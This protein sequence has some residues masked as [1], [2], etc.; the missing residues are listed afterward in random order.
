MGTTG[1]DE[2]KP[3]LKYLE[4][5]CGSLAVLVPF[6]DA[7]AEVSMSSYPI[8]FHANHFQAH[9]AVGAAIAAISFAYTVCYLLFQKI[10]NLNE[11]L[12]TSK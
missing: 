5:T 4:T 11:V 2:H 8:V 1:I 3:W 10:Q 12:G 9:P 6:K 7:L